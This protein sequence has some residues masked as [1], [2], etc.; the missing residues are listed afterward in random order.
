MNHFVDVTT[1][2]LIVG[3]IAAVIER[4]TAQATGREIASA[5]EPATVPQ[6]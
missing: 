5:I 4:E 1:Q 3:A 2:A 6:A